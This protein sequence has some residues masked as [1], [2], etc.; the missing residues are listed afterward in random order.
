MV[1]RCQHLSPA[2]LSEAVGKL[3]SIFGS[4]KEAN[5]VENQEER[6]RSVTGDLVLIERMAV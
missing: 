2:F 6:S 5:S 1:A 3:D 4:L